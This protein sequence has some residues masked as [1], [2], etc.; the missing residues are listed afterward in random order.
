MNIEQKAMR[1]LSRGRAYVVYH[2]PYVSAT[3]MALAPVFVPDIETMGVTPGLVLY[4][5]PVWATTD[6]ELNDPDPDISDMVVGT[7]IYHECWHP[8]RGMERLEALQ[9]HDL[10]NIAGD[11]CINED[12]L[13]DPD[14][15][16]LPSWVVH[17]ENMRKKTGIILP[18]GKTLEQYYRLLDQNQKKLSEFLQAL[19]EKGGA[20]PG[21]GRCGGAAGST[22]FKELERKL[23][24]AFGRDSLERQ[25]I[26]DVT[27]HKVKEYVKAHGRGSAPGS[28]EAD[29]TFKR[30]PPPINWE[31]T[32]QH[33]SKRATG[34]AI[35]G[36]DDFSMSR[37]SKRS[38]LLGIPRPG[39]VDHVFVPGFIRD[40]S[41]SMGKEQLNSANNTII[42]V[43]ESLGAERVWLLDAD[44]KLSAKPRMVLVKDIPALKFKGRGGTD[45]RQP[46]KEA[47]NLRPRPD[48]LF[49]L[50]DGDGT[51]PDKP[52]PFPVVWC[53]V[54][55]PHGV[56]PAKWGHV[57]VC[58][59]N[60]KL[61][62]QYA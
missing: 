39:L 29:I 59:K 6:P 31:R 52:P 5:D 60:Q 22:N 40:T 8:I 61:W 36:G 28:D 37:P 45:F 27:I 17:I 33:V 56:R 57:V 53:I 15:W 4:C 42:D 30:E 24:E 34:R 58:D 62:D 50:T 49:Y 55:T 1:M 16:R 14:T 7:C 54:P 3:C 46:L 43:M 20:K 13:K 18:P 11:I 38:M 23:D 2:A 9:N 21:S 19:S 12:I 47:E 26:R 35:A 32:L 25:V 10:A 44:T 41:A 51:A 48:V